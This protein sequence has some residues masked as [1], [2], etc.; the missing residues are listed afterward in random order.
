MKK[1]IQSLF[2]LMLTFSAWANEPDAQITF[3]VKDDSGVVVT[4]AVVQMN[5]FER[6]EPIGPYGKDIHR[7]VSGVTD[8]NGLVTLQLPCLRGSV[9]YSVFV[10]GDYYDQTM[11]MNV[12]GSSYYRDMGGNYYFTNSIDEKWQPWNPMLEIELKKVLNPI[13]MY[14]RFTRS[15]SLLI[16]AYNQPLGYDLIKSDWLPPYGKGETPD[17]IFNLDCQLE[18]GR[19]D[20]IQIFDAILTLTFSNDGDGIREILEAPK[21]GSAFHLPRFAPEA[22]YATNW[23]SHTF[24]HEDSDSCEYKEDQNFFYRVRASKDKAERVTNALYGKNNWAIIL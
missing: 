20:G 8:T 24:A 6:W 2:V 19:K 4:G 5:I 15:R 22:G 13:P 3:R 11:K 18:V 17:F 16:P 1:L 21:V 9:K 7:R 12:A 23:V 10:N 14:A